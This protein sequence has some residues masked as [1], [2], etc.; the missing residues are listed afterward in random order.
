[1]QAT[2]NAVF[3]VMIVNG[4]IGAQIRLNS[5]YGVLGPDP[6]HPAGATIG[7][8]VRLILQDLGG[9]IPGS[10][11]MSIN[12]AL[13]RYTGT[14][15]A[16]DEI[17]VPKTWQP[18]NVELGM[19][20]GTNTVTLQQV[21]GAVNV[22]DTEVTDETNQ[23]ACLQKIANYMSV[24]S[25]QNPYGTAGSA[26]IVFMGRRVAQGLADFGWTKD[27]VKQYLWDH[28]TIPWSSIKAVAKADDLQSWMD[29]GL[30]KTPNE[31]IH[32]NTD[33]S[34]ITIVVA[35]GAE[36][37]HGVWMQ[38]FSNRPRVIT[39]IKLP[40]NWNDLLKQA[41]KDLGPLPAPMSD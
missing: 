35:G 28:A 37:G 27:K 7:R 15:F 4:E 14:V 6:N 29:A 23:Y 2:T 25:G 21:S 40:K 13:G 20:P 32:I 5:G 31:P 17:G 1:M 36:G 8:A 11:T 22:G 3:P 16:E 41:E 24:Y 12:G 39:E 9:A 18:L 26:G 38:P 33:P 34:K 10:G 19:A 30:G